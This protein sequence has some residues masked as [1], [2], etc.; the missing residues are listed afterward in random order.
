[1]LIAAG[2]DVNKPDKRGY[3][4][5]HAASASGNENIL[6]FLI[7]G[8]ADV[9][10][11]DPD[12]CTPCYV[13]S[14]NGWDRIL[15]MLIPAGADVNKPDK[16]GRTPLDMAHNHKK[17]VDVLLANNAVGNID[18][19]MRMFFCYHALCKD[20]NNEEAETLTNLA[21][22]LFKQKHKEMK[23]CDYP[24][25]TNEWEE[26]DLRAC[27]YCYAVYYCCVDHQRLRWPHHKGMCK[28]ISKCYKATEVG[29][30]KKR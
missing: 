14:Q 13:A 24:D 10:Q 22:K 25:C 18:A 2:S 1:M 7:A 17:A 11:S 16:C 27:C 4:P 20:N 6:S 8:G 30:N 19:K 23:Y 9:N 29:D 21:M 15:S 12:G 28:E 26:S 3:T 5:C